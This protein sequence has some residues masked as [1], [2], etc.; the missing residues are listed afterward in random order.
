MVAAANPAAGTTL[1]FNLEVDFRGTFATAVALT[2]VVGFASNSQY[3][4]SGQLSTGDDLQYY[5]FKSPS[6]SNGDTNTLRAVVRTIDGSNPNVVLS[7]YNSNKQVVA[8][9]V[10][11]AGNGTYVVEAAGLQSNAS[12]YVMVA[13]ADGTTPPAATLELDFRGNVSTAQ[14]LTSDAGYAANAHYTIAGSLLGASD[15]NVYKFK[16]ISFGTG[17]VG[18]LRIALTSPGTDASDFAV[19]LLDKNRAPVAFEVLEQ[20][21]DSF[22][23]RASNLASGADYYLEVTSPATYAVGDRVPLNIELDFRGTY[24][25]AQSLVQMKDSNGTRFEATARLNDPTDQSVFKFKLPGSGSLS[26][27]TIVGWTPVPNQPAPDL[28][29]STSTGADVPATIAVSGN[30][31]TIVANGLKTGVDYYLRVRATVASGEQTVQLVIDGKDDFTTALALKATAGYA[32]LSNYQ[33]SGELLALADANFFRVE[34]TKVS[35]SNVFTLTAQ[36]IGA[37]TAPVIQVYDVKQNPLSAV[38]LQNANGQ[39]VIQVTDSKQQTDSNGKL[40]YF[41]TT[42]PGVGQYRLTADFRSTYATA[43]ELEETDGFAKGTHYQVSSQFGG[44][45]DVQ[46]YKFDA[47]SITL[48]ETKVLTLTATSGSATAGPPAIAVYNMKQQSVPVTVV[49][50]ANGS[51]SVRFTDTQQPDATTNQNFYYVR[52]TP[53]TGTNAGYAA[54][55]LT[56]DLRDSV[57]Y[58]QQLSADA[59]AAGAKVAYTVSDRLIDSTDVKVMKFKSAKLNTG[60]V[61]VM[62][63]TVKVLDGQALP[64]ITVTDDH[65]TVLTPTEVIAL[66]ADTYQV[67]FIGMASDKDFYLTVANGTGRIATDILFRDTAGSKGLMAGTAGYFTNT[68]YESAGSLLGAND[69]VV[70]SFVS[71]KLANGETGTV[72]VVLWMA[73]PNAAVPQVTLVDAAGKVVPSQVVSDGTGMLEVRATNLFANKQYSVQIRPAAG[74]AA[75]VTTDFD[76]L[77]DFRD[78]FSTATVLTNA[79]GYTKNTQYTTTGSLINATDNRMFSVTAPEFGKDEPG[80]LTITLWGLETG[81]AA[82]VVQVFDKSHNLVNGMTLSNVNGKYILGLKGLSAGQTYFLEVKAPPSA[83]FSKAFRLEANFV[84]TFGTARTIAQPE[85][86]GPHTVFTAAGTVGA[87]SGPDIFEIKAPKRHETETSLMTVTVQTSDGSAVAPRV[88]VYDE[89]GQAVAFELLL[90]ENGTYRVQIPVAESR[91]Y[92][93]VVQTRDANM[94]NQVAYKLTTEFD[95]RAPQFTSSMLGALTASSLQDVKQL[96]VTESS[97]MYFRLGVSFPTTSPSGVSVAVRMTI[98]DANGNVLATVVAPDGSGNAGTIKVALPKGTYFVRL[99]AMTS[100]GSTLPAVSYTLSMSIL[101]DP[102]G[103]AVT[104]PTAAPAAPIT[105]GGTPIAAPTYTVITPAPTTPAWLRPTDMYAN[106]WWSFPA[107]APAVWTNPVAV[108]ES[109][110]VS[111]LAPPDVVEVWATPIAVDAVSWW[112]W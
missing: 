8:A 36:V 66:T 107:P 68:H 49:E 90:N 95:L 3:S 92:F 63:L 35:G 70:Y 39:Y 94:A 41:I 69:L 10:L 96:D 26:Q 91:T 59:S 101:T 84:D 30:K 50:N 89:N 45:G 74:T 57:K 64:R 83:G 67:R 2:S 22:V 5:S 17:D 13:S 110:S 102:I 93:V 65:Q 55:G 77:I 109:T 58:S 99:S 72:S 47:A 54:Y 62:V 7:L 38:V 103:P 71:P 40:V 56:I 20:T 1:G 52:L 29:L 21:F 18:V 9:Q 105:W 60:E 61:N 6:L 44:I 75:G 98:Y 80:A 43:V 108:A 51:Y 87:A 34:A 88:K 37:G 76:L 73:D 100:N 24:A 14:V 23:I 12:Y 112:A 25:A 97:I 33:T 19:R 111:L 16:S 81:L 46:F 86:S 4:V 78:T 106:P 82:P 104:D 85:R 28:Y 48:G 15:A 27:A 32:P 11:N 79:T 31:V 53:G 42:G